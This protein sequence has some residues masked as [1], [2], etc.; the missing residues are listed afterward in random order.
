L[1]KVNICDDILLRNF[2]PKSQLVTQK[3]P[4]EAPC[5]PVIDAYNYLGGAFALH[6]KQGTLVSTLSAKNMAFLISK[7]LQQHHV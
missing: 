6:P 4:F 5:R 3:A 7:M 2:R 1:R